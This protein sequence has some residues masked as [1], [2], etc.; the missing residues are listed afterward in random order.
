MTKG[1]TPNEIR[2][3]LMRRGVKLIDVASRAGVTKEAVSQAISG[4][5]KYKGKKRVRP[6]IADI[7]GMPVTDIWPDNIN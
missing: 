3:E 4:T 5:K 1:L 2:A 6:V 7:I